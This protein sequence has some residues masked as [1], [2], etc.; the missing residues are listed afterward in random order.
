MKLPHKLRLRLTTILFKARAVESRNHD[1][2]RA[3]PDENRKDFVETSRE[4][5]VKILIISNFICRI[6][7]EW[8]L[9]GISF[10]DFGTLFAFLDLIPQFC[11]LKSIQGR[12]W[13]LCKYFFW[14]AHACKIIIWWFK[15][16]ISAISPKKLN[17]KPSY[18]PLKMKWK[19]TN[20][21]KY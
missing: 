1:S 11:R 21:I 20:N 2:Y 15:A 19:S 13:I 10:W 7:S 9:F 6:K 17:E 14:L 3:V 18:K 4:D 5:G 8:L 16:E 12:Y